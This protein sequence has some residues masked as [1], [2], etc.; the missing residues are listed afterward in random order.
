MLLTNTCPNSYCHTTPPMLPESFQEYLLKRN[1]AANTVLSYV[2]AVKQ[3]LRLYG[4]V[5]PS[6]L[7][8]YKIY[9]LE[10][11]KPQTVN[12]RIRAINC[13]MEAGQLTDSRLTMLRVQQKMYA[14]HIISEADYEYLKSCLLQD[15]KYLYYFIIRYMAAT[16]VRV[17]ELVEIQA[18]DVTRGYRDIF[19]KGGKYRRIYIPQRLQ[20]ASLQWL[21]HERITKGDIFRNRFGNRISTGGIRT[22]LKNMA[23]RYGLDPVVVYP[24]SFRHRFAKSFIERCSDISFLSDL[25]GHESLETTRIYLRRT[26]TEQQHI[27]N[28]VVN[29]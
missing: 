23:I 3:F 24:H 13:Y 2:F 29:W 14:D 4:Q 20:Q 18:E 21:E 8:L 27:V 22:V 15:E 12:L 5:T 28:K 9:L 11:Y 6:N 26:S 1:M 10:H 7:Q 25:L 16:G 17:S 19:S